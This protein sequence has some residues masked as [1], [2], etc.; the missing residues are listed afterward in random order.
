[1]T[2]MCKIQEIRIQEESQDAILRGKSP[3][4]F[5]LMYGPTL[6]CLVYFFVSVF[7]IEFV[8]I[9]YNFTLSFSIQHSYTNIL[10]TVL[11]SLT[12]II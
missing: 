2:L 7:E 12:D 11:N 4:V 3:F 10:L 1:M 8:I 5:C 9:V 6:P